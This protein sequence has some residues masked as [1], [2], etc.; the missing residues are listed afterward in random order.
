MKQDLPALWAES[1]G[2][3]RREPIN[4]ELAGGF[5]CGPLDLNLWNELIYRLSQVYREAATA[6]TQSGQ[7]LNQNNTGQLWTAIQRSSLIRAGAD[8][9]PTA[10]QIVIPTL[11][12]A[13]PDTLSDYQLFEVVPNVS[14]TGAAT[15][16]LG[17]NNPLPLQRR[18][19]AA[20]QDGDAPAGQPFLVVKLGS[21]LRR[22]DAT[23]SEIR[24]TAGA[25]QVFQSI[26]TQ[27]Y[28]TPLTYWR[29]DSP[30]AT[31]PANTLT[32]ITNYTNRTATVNTGTDVSQGSGVVTI[33]PS[34]AGVY[35]M[36][37]TNAMDI[38]TTEESIFIFLQRA[39]T[40]FESAFAIST[41]RGPYPSPGNNAND[42]SV[43]AIYR[44]AV[45]DK[46]FATYRQTNDGNSPS[47]TLN[48]PLGHFGG[49][50]VGG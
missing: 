21:S 49:V 30:S 3:L 24:A 13:L 10:N 37:A 47:S 41:A 17:T 44:L 16:K 5:P 8:T 15:V 6:I 40:S 42:Q 25:P 29:M 33:G 9:S 14:V 35:I 27:F 43:S 22:L 18:D 12:P 23:V 48:Q 11:S 19:G 34:D 1:P 20:F 46:V 7:T 32:A 4:S 2:A 26:L 38:P 45:G 36:T 28:A 39:G 31:I 50:R